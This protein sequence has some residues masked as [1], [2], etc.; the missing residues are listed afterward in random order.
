MLQPRLIRAVTTSVMLLMLLAN[1][2]PGA[3]WQSKTIPSGQ[4]AAAAAS[5]QPAAGTTTTYEPQYKVEYQTVYDTESYQVPV[6]RTETRYRTEYS[7][8][9]RPGHAMGGRAGAGDADACGAPAG[10]A[11]AV[12][13]GDTDDDRTG[14]RNGSAYPL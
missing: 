14:G 8:A 4:A 6:T 7:D 5:G 11:S 3:P 12:G 2:V 9:D 13:P 1:P 10:N